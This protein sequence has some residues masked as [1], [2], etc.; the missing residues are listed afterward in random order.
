MDITQRTL[1]TVEELA[2][3]WGFKPQTIREMEKDGKILRVKN[4]SG[5]RFSLHDILLIEQDLNPLSPLERKRLELEIKN[6]DNEIA[7]LKDIISRLIVPLGEYIAQY[8]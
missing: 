8:S 4:I 5:V 1:L 3:R 7:K 6:K 2:K